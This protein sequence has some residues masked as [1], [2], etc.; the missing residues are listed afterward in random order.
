MN[1]HR[2]GTAFYPEHCIL[3]G[4]PML[5]KEQA[6]S[7]IAQAK[8]RFPEKFA[9]Q[10]DYFFFELRY[11]APFDK[12][13]RELKRPQ[14]E[15]AAAAGR[16]DEFRGYIILN[17]SEYLT[18]ED[19]AY[20]TITLQFLADMSD[21]WKYILLVDST[22][23]RQASAMIDRILSLFVQNNIPCEVKEAVAVPPDR[24]PVSDICA[25][26][27]VVCSRPV[28]TLMQRLLDQGF[29]EKVI[30]TLLRDISWHSGQK[31][32]WLAIDPLFSENATSSIVRYVLPE[33]EYERLLAVIQQQR[34]QHYGEKETI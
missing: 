26:L 25:E 2:H 18:H 13:F 9:G 33:K 27:N 16:R 14:G 20:F 10:K 3:L 7:I 30:R 21:T 12:S 23:R 11:V 1:D 15:A 22:N 29:S 28:A 6:M 31:I 5:L 17:L 19:E 8:E 32:C 34:K 24:S 4:D